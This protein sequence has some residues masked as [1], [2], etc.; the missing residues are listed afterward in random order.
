MVAQIPRSLV[1][2]GTLGGPRVGVGAMKKMPLLLEVPAGM[3][4]GRAV[5]RFSLLPLLPGPSKGHIQ[6]SSWQRSLK[7][8][9]NR[10]AFQRRCKARNGLGA[11]APLMVCIS[12][13]VKGK[14]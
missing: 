11:E 2:A 8:T 10:A 3:E 7:K 6:E 5:H 9:T 4:R 1:E 14:E 13:E 12:K